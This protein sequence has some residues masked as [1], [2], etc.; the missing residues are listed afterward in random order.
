MYLCH[1]FCEI[2]AVSMVEELDELRTFLDA[3]PDDVLVLV[4]ED[5]VSPER[6]RQEFEAARLGHELFPVEPGATL[7]TLGAMVRADQR[8]LVSLENGDGGPT[9][10]NAFTGLVQETPFTFLRPSALDGATSCVPN[11]GVAGSPI[12]QFNHW[13]TP[14]TRGRARLVNRAELPRSGRPLHEGARA[15]ADARGG[16][17]RGEQRRAVRRRR[18][19]PRPAPGDALARAHAQVGPAGGQVCCSLSTQRLRHSVGSP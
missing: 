6:I 18:R 5:Y 4:I 8:L 13:V 3:H 10:P 1:T 16:R 15:R 9:L 14:P 17:L 2:G 19:R 11:R 12:F 7:P